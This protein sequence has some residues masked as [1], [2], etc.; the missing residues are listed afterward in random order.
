MIF[1]ECLEKS[2]VQQL[3]NSLGNWQVA[4]QLEVLGGY[5]ISKIKKVV[6]TI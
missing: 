3:L 5:D 2:Q 1:R 6:T 4:Q